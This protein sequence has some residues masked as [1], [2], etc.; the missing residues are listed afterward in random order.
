MNI[1]G[2]WVYW[3]EQCKYCVNATPVCKKNL[4]NYIE[5]LDAVKPINP[6]YGTLE[7]KCD[8]FIFDK[9]KYYREN[10]GECSNAK[11]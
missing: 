5:K 10:A 4:K 6:V 11:I 7:F 9:D 1:N 3:K 8:Y 2:T